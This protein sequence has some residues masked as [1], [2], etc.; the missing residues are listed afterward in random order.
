[1]LSARQV[2]VN[3]AIWRS[4]DFVDRYA[5]RTLEP[6][7]ALLLARYREPLSGRTLEFGCGAGRLLGYLSQLGLEANGVDISL[8]MVAHCRRTYPQA[9]VQAGDISRP[10]LC[11]E[12]QFDAIWITAAVLDTLDDFARRRVLGE[13]AGM[14]G[15]NG[16]LIFS[17]HNLDAPPPGPAR[18]R[19]GLRGP[20]SVR[21][22]RALARRAAATSP[23]GALR[24][25]T[26]AAA[27]WRRRRALAP[28]TF[29]GERHAVLNDGTHGYRLLHYY[30][31]RGDQ[32]RQLEGLG[33]AL[34]ECLDRDG[35]V[36]G[37][38]ERSASAELYYVAYP[39]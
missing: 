21:R 8:R 32:E 3:Q 37:A 36:V 35:R 34:I 5:V 23:A 15:S 10:R 1:M 30:I 22:G 29:R 27:A 31:R 9:H 26:E 39:R 33:Y 18:L 24:V 6:V 11:G 12:G 19:D 2:A 38:G 14:I 25:A 16:I 28:L 13:I 7:E 4:V 17:T 20:W